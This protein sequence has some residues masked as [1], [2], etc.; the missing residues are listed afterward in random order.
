MSCESNREDVFLIDFGAWIEKTLAENEVGLNALVAASGMHY[1]YLK[2]LISSGKVGKPIR[3]DQ[4]TVRQIGA[5][6][7]HLKLIGQAAEAEIVAGYIP[8]GYLVKQPED[9]AAEPPENYSDYPPELQE[10]LAFAGALTPAAKTLVYQLWREQA[11]AHHDIEMIRREAERKLN[12]REHELA[13][14]GRSLAGK[15]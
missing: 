11:R 5:G 8:E 14:M 4:D 12:E 7:A 3:P 6:L 2:R 10:A 9:L 13:Q 15:S 1:S